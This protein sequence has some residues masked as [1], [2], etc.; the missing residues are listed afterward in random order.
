MALAKMERQVRRY[1]D[2]IRSHQ[3]S[4][5]RSAKIRQRVF[6]AGISRTP[7]APEYVVP[8]SP[9]ADLPAVIREREFK[10]DRLDLQQAIMQM[11]LLHK[12]CLV[13]TN[14]K[15]GDINVVYRTEDD[16]YGVIETQGHVE[17]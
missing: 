6:D 17:D 8:V 16:N 9:Q 14:N 5:G 7:D 15:T 12:A 3:P 13:F 1:K 2:R 11:N 4:R 10:A